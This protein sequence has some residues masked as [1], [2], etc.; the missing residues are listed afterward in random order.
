MT[1]EQPLLKVE[2]LVVHHGAAQA[3]F[4]VSF[5]V[6]P[7]TALALLG[8]NGAG[9]STIAR[10]LS[11]LV[12]S[13]GVIEFAGT[14]IGGWRAHRIRQA[15]LVYLPEGRGIFP[16]LSV[17][18]NLKMATDGLSSADRRA[19]YAKV[20]ELF[21]V[22]G[23]RRG[24]V[25][26]SMSG[27]EQQM[28]SLARAVCASPSLVI[29]DEMS[30]GLAPKL[31]DS[32]F[33]SLQRMLASGVAIVLIEQFVQRALAFAS[34]C[35]VVQRGR[36]AWSGEAAASREEIVSRYLGSAKPA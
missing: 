11:G 3:L 34:E 14:E 26:G 16:G 24:Q 10:A 2:D 22:L 23:Q 36:V 27:G 25:A 35:V 12:P 31:V 33:E 18:D 28:L 32:V 8:A 6:R 19:T 5:Q 29:A 13:R 30:L 9:K 1:G 21:P 7:G 17:L 15:G 20:Y 4:G